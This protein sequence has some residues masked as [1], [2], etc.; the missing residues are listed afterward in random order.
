M[1]L[2]PTER[3]SCD[4]NITGGVIVMSLIQTLKLPC[5]CKVVDELLVFTIDLSDK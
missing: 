1:T 5:L 4:M 2:S 3:P